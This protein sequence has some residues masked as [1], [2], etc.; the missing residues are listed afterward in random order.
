M[1]PR[2]NEP[3]DSF[4]L[5]TDMQTK[6][7]AGNFITSN[8]CHLTKVFHTGDFS[9][10]VKHIDKVYAAK[11]PNVEQGMVHCTSIT[12]TQIGWRL[13]QAIRS[14]KLTQ[15]SAVNGVT[16]AV[17]QLHAIG[18]AHCDLSLENVFMD[19][20]SGTV[21]VG[22]L[23]RC[24]PL[25]DAPPTEDDSVRAECSAGSAQDLDNILLKKL[26]EEIA[27]L[28]ACAKNKSVNFFEN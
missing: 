23:D 25:L 15:E 6:T 10:A 11:L 27:E 18:L 21:F 14:H 7:R 4:H 13:E 3:T 8:K 26:L 9:A 19:L 24:R 22:G 2:L 28:F 20:I 16:Q 1:D 5:M 17:Q 12:I